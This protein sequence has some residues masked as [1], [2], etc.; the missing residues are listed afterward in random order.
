MATV[1]RFEELEVSN[2]ARSQCNEVYT[3]M[4]AGA[5]KEDGDLRGQMNRSSASVMDNIGEGFER[6]TTGDF[7]H[8]LVMAKG[9][10][11]EMR[12]QIHRMADRNPIPVEQYGSLITANN[13][14]A[15]NCT[16]L[17]NIWTEVNT[18]TRAAVVLKLP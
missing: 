3:L 5:F 16:H 17:L 9:S 12:S 2:L 8:F 6:Y 14:W 4:R 15:K 11:R 7:R 10:N 1:K 18:R 13:R